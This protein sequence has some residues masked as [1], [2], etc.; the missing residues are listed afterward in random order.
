MSQ[1]DFKKYW[2]LKLPKD[3]FEQHDVRILGS[4]PNGK[5]NQLIYLKLLLESIT[6][7]GELRF[8]QELPYTNEMLATICEVDKETMDSAMNYL[9]SLGLVEITEDETIVLTEVYKMIGCETGKAIRSREYREKKKGE[10]AQT[11]PI[12]AQNEPNSSP[13]EPKTSREIEIEKELEIDK[14]NESKDSKRKANNNDSQP[15]LISFDLD[16]EEGKKG[17]LEHLRWLQSKDKDWK[18]R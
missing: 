17:M 6:H 16:T 1:T 7:D 2:Y 18:G 14:E 10:G 11:S 8:N 12:R 9:K 13:N 15:D 5:I 4:M 3:F